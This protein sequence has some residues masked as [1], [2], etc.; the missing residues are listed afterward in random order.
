MRASAQRKYIDE[1]LANLDQ[2]EQ[3][4]DAEQTQ[5]AYEDLFR[6]CRENDLDLN[7]V[8]QQPRTRREGSG[9]IGTLKALWPAS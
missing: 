3:C 4:L 9:I 6:F 2:A 5:Q 8:L 1:L 7:T